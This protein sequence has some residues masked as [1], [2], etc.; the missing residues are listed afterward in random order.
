MKPGS[1]IVIIILLGLAVPAVAQTPDKY[2]GKG[3][4]FLGDSAASLGRAGTGVSSFGTEYFYLN[5]ASI[6]GLERTGISAQYGSLPLQIKS[7]NPDVT[8][9]VPLSYGVLGTSFR[10]IYVPDGKDFKKGYSFSIGGAKDFTQK[11]ML[12]FAFNYFHG[13]PGSMDYFGGMLGIIY[14]FAGTDRKTGFGFFDPKAGFSVSFGLPTGKSKSGADFN[15]VTAGYNFKFFRTR[16]FSLG[17][18]NDVSALNYRHFPVKTGLESE[19]FSILV[20]RFGF[21]LPREYDYGY[22]TGGAGLKFSTSYFDG[23]LNYAF[24]YCKYKK[25]THYVGLNMEY[26]ML[27]NTPPETNIGYD[28]E[29]ISPNHDGVQ[30]YVQFTSKVADQSRIKGW[31]LQISDQDGSLVREF[32]ISDRD[33]I[34]ELTFSGFFKRLFQTKESVIVPDTIMWDGTDRNGRTVPDGK[35]D[36]SFYAWDARDNISAK[37]MGKIFVDNKP[38][39]AKLLT[40]DDLFS[41]NGD[42]HKD[43]YMIRQNIKTDPDDEWTACFRDSAGRTVKKYSW[44]GSE[45]PNRIIWDGRDDANKDVPEGLYGYTIT[46]TDRAGNKITAEIRE[47]TLT[48]QYEVADIALSSEYFSYLKDGDVNAFPKLSRT[49]G[50]LSWKITVRNAKKTVKEIAGAGELPRLVKWDGLDGE[51]GK[52]DDGEYFVKFSASFKSGNAPESFEKRLIVDSTPPDLKIGHTPGLFSPDNDGDNDLLLISSRAYDRFGIKD[53]KITIT[54][55]SGGAFKV[56]EGKGQVPAQII[57]DGLGDGRD[58][59]ESA[60]D[61]GLTLEASDFA[62][63]HSRSEKDVIEVDILVIV[64]ERG[65]KMR[66]SNIEFDFG[67]ESLTGKGKDIL[68]RV[69]SILKKYRGYDITVEGHTD[70]IGKD[71]LNLEL[72]ERRAKSVMNYLIGKGMDEGRIRFMGMG[73]TVPLYPNTTDENRRRNRRVEFLLIKRTD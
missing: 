54:S 30:D 53:W 19:L 70:D 28:N 17:L 59:V 14:K 16:S 61:Y 12:G 15:S 67:S 21:I 42:R 56:F 60:A 39:E 29:F 23:S 2:S 13:L 10:Y 11:V 25:F 37:R 52:L 43:F 73:E 22:F 5:P 34:R 44:K 3:L 18:F 9:A 31:K 66:I 35:Y 71:D 38:P 49:Q 41:P 64:T 33:M 62:G 45:V 48:R 72:S 20:L 32:K 50:L 6:A 40:D 24:N 36:Y 57:W 69:Y 27:D 55:P 46:G 1:I 4:Y 51:G 68:D 63:N 26:G 65:L 58:L 47:I 8:L 7:K